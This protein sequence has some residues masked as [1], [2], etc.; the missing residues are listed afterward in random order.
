MIAV[1]TGIVDMLGSDQQHE[2]RNGANGCLGL[3]EMLGG[4]DLR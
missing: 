4:M 1:C 3:E 2:G